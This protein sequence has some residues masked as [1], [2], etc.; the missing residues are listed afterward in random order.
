[1]ST[2]QAG[3]ELDELVAREVLGWEYV[4]DAPPGHWCAV[5][6]NNS[7]WWRRPGD[8]DW[9]CAACMS[10][11]QFSES[12]ED[13]WEIV[14]HMK[15][16]GWEVSLHSSEFYRHHAIFTHRVRRGDVYPQ[17]SVVSDTVPLAICLAARAAVLKL[18]GTS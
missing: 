3:R 8:E 10:F 11:P 6:G 7:G 4:Q 16:Q 17:G 1:M 12:I 14:E 15:K 9:A 5:F 2:L 18:G 13:A